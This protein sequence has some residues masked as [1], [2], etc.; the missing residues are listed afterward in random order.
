MP[1]IRSSLLMF[2]WKF[3][4]IPLLQGGEPMSQKGIF[5]INIK[6]KDGT[7]FHHKEFFTTPHGEISVSSVTPLFEKP[8]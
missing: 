3:T 2:C 6:G 5:R 4:D 1:A 8:F 7:P